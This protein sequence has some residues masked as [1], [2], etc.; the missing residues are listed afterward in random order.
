MV[1]FFGG[2]TVKLEFVKA[3]T[4]WA[5]GFADADPADEA[6]AETLLVGLCADA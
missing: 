4:D 6:A 3:V 5:P 1:T 2:L